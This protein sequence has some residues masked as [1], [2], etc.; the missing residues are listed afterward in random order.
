MTE[1]RNLRMR[2]LMVEFHDGPHATPAAATDGPVYLGIKNITDAGALDLSDVR[3]IA[4]EDFATWT[5]R[6]TPLPG[7]VVFTYE[8]TLHRYALI[9]HGFRGCLGRRLALIRVDPTIVLP[10]FLHYVLL[11]P[12]WRATVTDRI[13][14]GSTVDRVP[15][16]SFPDFPIAIPDLPTQHGIVAT[17]GSIDDLIE[18]NRRRIDL[19]EQ[20]AQAIYRE[21]FVRLRYPGHEAHALVDSPLG[22]IP[23]G[24]M[25]TTIG[26]VASVNA[27]SRTPRRDET[28]QYLDISCLG[29]RSLTPPPV[30]AGEA[31]PGRARRVVHPGDI[32]WSMVRPGRRAH[33]LLVRPGDDWIASTGLAVLSSSQISTSLLFETV[34]ATAFSDYLVSQEGGS[35]YP[36]V[37]PHDF[38]AGPILRPPAE[39]DRAFDNFVA[40]LHRLGW[41]LREA[42]ERLGS[43]RDLLLP[44]LVTGQIDVS[45]LELDALVDSVA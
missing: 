1:W 5:R 8:A 31:A 7:D 25:V 17:L 38:S 6:V 24:W 11:G 33:A 42:S 27:E 16:V 35:A 21:W 22:P 13:I 44:K 10:R 26:A 30:V 14:S 9:P 34:S 36:A 43:I 15:I 3:H 4:E 23:P 37:K 29:D 40:P 20:M 32:V 39:V 45:S 19:L 28:I 41:Q 2:D 12:Q 18:N